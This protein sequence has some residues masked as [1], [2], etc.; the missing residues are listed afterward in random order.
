MQLRKPNDHSVCTSPRNAILS[1]IERSILVAPEMSILNAAV[2]LYLAKVP[3]PWASRSVGDLWS[4]WVVRGALASGSVG[5]SLFFE[6]NTNG[7]VQVLCCSWSQNDWIGCHCGVRNSACR[8]PS[9]LPALSGQPRSGGFDRAS[10]YKYSHP[11][12]G[13]PNS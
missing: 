5:S 1:R 9:P 11:S 2:A 10:M 4:Q 8:V 3:W 7:H 12:Q 6:V 13:C